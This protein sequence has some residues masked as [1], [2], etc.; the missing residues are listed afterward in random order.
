[1][2]QGFQSSYA[3]NL[4]SY[5]YQGLT[6]SS[7]LKRTVPGWLIN[8]QGKMHPRE[9]AYTSGNN[10]HHNKMIVCTACIRVK[11]DSPFG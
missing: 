7:C 10:V 3:E 8:K 4:K 2:R 1:M 5:V 6:S 9:K 11:Y